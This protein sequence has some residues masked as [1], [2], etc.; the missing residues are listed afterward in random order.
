VFDGKDKWWKC[1]PVGSLKPNGYGLYDMAGNVWE[2]TADWYDERYYRISP[3]KNPIGS[4][5]GKYRVLRGGPW[6]YLTAALRVAARSYH[7]PLGS[8]SGGFRCVAD[9][10]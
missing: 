2:W 6:S 4:A 3:S 5:N 7:D 10:E 9:V 8:S 1:S